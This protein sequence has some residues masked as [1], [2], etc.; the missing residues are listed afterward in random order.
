MSAQ[1]AT[2]TTVHTLARMKREG[3]RIVC[4]TCYDAGF[5][6]LEEAAGVDVM[7]VGDSLGMVVQG[8]ETTLPVSVD[9]MIY[10]CAAVARAR[11]KA[12]LAVDMPFMS[13]NTPAE[14]LANAG[15][16]MKEGEAQMVKLEGGAEQVATVAHLVA[17]GVPVC[18]HLGLLPQSVHKLGGYRVQGREADAAARMIEEAKALEAAGA[19]LMVVECIPSALAGR[20]RAALSIPVIGIGAGADCDGQVLVLYD[21]LGMNGGHVP[22]FVKNF[23][24]GRDSIQEAIAGYARAVREGEFPAAEHSFDA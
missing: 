20:L 17:H 6:A 23:L 3:K 22:K 21:M 4:L 2:Q 1:G 16:L 10:H 9:D 19:G 15:R 7:L 14:A 12:L 8:R 11:R 13:Y 18:S 24:A 5:A